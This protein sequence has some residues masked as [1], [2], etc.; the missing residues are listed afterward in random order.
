MPGDFDDVGIFFDGKS[1]LNVCCGCSWSGQFLHQK[2]GMETSS[3]P[4]WL[5]SVLRLELV[6]ECEFHNAAAND[7]T[8]LTVK[9]A[10]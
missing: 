10:G 6:L 8:G 2:K 1:D 4:F 7:S 5:C 3:M 9:A